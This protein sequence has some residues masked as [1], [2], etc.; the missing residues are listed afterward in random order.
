MRN[1]CKACLLCTGGGA[2]PQQTPWLEASRQWASDNLY[3]YVELS[4]T[5]SRTGTDTGRGPD[6]GGTCT[7]LH[8]DV[9][10]LCM[11]K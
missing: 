10:V 4:S 7:E 3:E 8:E 1:L 6:G 11:V 5:S 9:C 2:E